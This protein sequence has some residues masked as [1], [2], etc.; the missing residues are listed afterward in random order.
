MNPICTRNIFGIEVRNAHIKLVDL[1]VII[2]K[3]QVPF[4]NAI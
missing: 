3:S 2:C 4:Y 1:E